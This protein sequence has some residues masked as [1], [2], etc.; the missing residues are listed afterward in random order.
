VDNTA[1][2]TDRLIL[3]E[4]LERVGVVPTQVEEERLLSCYLKR[5]NALIREQPGRVLPG[6]RVLLLRLAR[7][8]QFR[9]GLGTGNLEAAARLKLGLHGL[10]GFFETGGFGDDSL[11]RRDVIAAGL[12]KA[13]KEYRVAFQRVIIIGDTP[14]DIAAGKENGVHSVAVATGLYS[15]AVLK[16]HKPTMVISDMKEPEEFIA[17]LQELPPIPNVKF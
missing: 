17:R 11:H 15:V 2:K 7:N 13:Y 8:E 6:V 14:G 16:R 5:V 12:R 9:I 3:R 4:H 1:G 10:N